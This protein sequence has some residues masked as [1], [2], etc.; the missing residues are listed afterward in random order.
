MGA[1]F[2]APF[3]VDQIYP[4]VF[5]ETERQIP[6][7]GSGIASP[8]RALRLNKFGNITALRAG[9]LKKRRQNK[10]KFLDVPLNYRSPRT[11]HL[12]AG[13][14]QIKGA[15]RRRKLVMIVAYREQ[16]TI[17]PKWSEY[18]RVVRQSYQDNF[19]KF[20]LEGFQRE[21]SKL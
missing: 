8:T 4:N 5:R 14:Y 18:P 7:A 3:L 12:A 21:V 15:G 2:I 6:R 19:S 13:L 20:W 10:T 11:K 16:R 1:V 17:T 9:A